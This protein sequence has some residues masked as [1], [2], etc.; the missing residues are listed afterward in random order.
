[1]LMPSFTLGLAIAAVLMRQVRAAMLDVLHDEYITTAR[2]KGLR[3]KTVITRHALRN[4]M[5][6][7]LTIIGLSTGRLIGGSVV[8]E[9]IFSIPGIGRLAVASIF[10]RDFPVVQGI[11]LVMALA[12]LLVNLA[13]DMLYGYVDPRIRNG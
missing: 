6:P 11:V 12:V 3:Q 2:A 9:T 10:A 8:V 4:A 5:I 7:V 1:M 13:T